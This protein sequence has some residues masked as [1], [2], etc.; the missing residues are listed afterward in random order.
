MKGGKKKVKSKRTKKVLKSI[1]KMSR[2]SL[3]AVK[4]F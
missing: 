3:N 1:N 4:A 2:L